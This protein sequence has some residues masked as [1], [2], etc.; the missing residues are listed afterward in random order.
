[1]LHE[2]AIRNVAL[3]DRL[4]VEFGDGLNVITG[5]S[6]AGKSIVI[7]AL[8]LALGARAGAAD[9][10]PWG[11]RAEVVARF[12][13]SPAARALLAE[14]DLPAEREITVRRVV[15]A[16]ESRAWL[17]GTPLALS[18]LKRLGETLLD[19]HGQHEHQTLLYPENYTRILDA[20]GGHARELAAWQA[21]FTAWRQA[22]D[23]HAAAQRATQESAQALD[24]YRFQLR[25]ISEAGLRDGEEEELKHER[26]QLRHAGDIVAAVTGGAAALGDDGG[27]LERLDNLEAALE[28]VAD[29]YAAAAGRL[30]EVREAKAVLQETR[31]E[32]RCAGEQISDDPQRLNEVEERQFLIQQLK[33]KYGGSIAA[34]L[35]YRD[36]LEQRVRRVDHRDEELA[37]LAAA[38]AA[39]AAGATAAAR[40]LTAA[41]AKAAKQFAA[42]IGRELKLLGLPAAEFG[43]TLVALP[44][45]ELR[46]AESV[47]FM[48]TA[49]PG[50]GAQPL[51]RVAS[52]GEISRVMLAVKTV[53]AKESPV[54]TMVFDEIDTGIS[55][56]V[57]GQVADRLRAA[58]KNQQVICI[59]HLPAIA[60]AGNRHFRVDKKTVKGAATVRLAAVTGDDRIE[61]VAALFAP[62][63]TAASRAAARELL[64]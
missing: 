17:D 10:G 35:A 64:C 27:I 54:P 45:W 7:G 20:F 58:A 41:R 14:L 32:L 59:T 11:D 55:G 33:K 2:L 47:E 29:W 36:E 12:G 18:L 48:F 3:I 26:E 61:E 30:Q 44:A 46:G 1:M 50:H 43:V 19:L 6:G 49:N 57:A 15:A 4:N 40:A 42:G 25:E 16:G 9:I 23:A 13:L 53:L 51:N 5:P 62:K 21:A 38:V 34:V 60:A 39:A 63:I 37:Q 24:L 56:E 22:T 52:G 31:H 28:A 8:G